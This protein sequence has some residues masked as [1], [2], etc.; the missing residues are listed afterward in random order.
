MIWAPCRH[1]WV[2]TIRHHTCIV[3]ESIDWQ[4]LNTYLCFR[5]LIFTTERHQHCRTTDCSIECFDKTFLSQYVVVLQVV[6]ETSTQCVAFYFTSKWIAFFYRTHC[7]ISK[8]SST[9]RIDKF[10]REV[11]N[12]FATIEHTH[13]RSISYIGNMHHFD[14]LFGAIFHELVFIFCLNYYRY[15]FLRLRDSEFCSVQAA[16]FCFHLVEVDIKTIS[17]LTDCHRYT[18]STEV[19]RFLNQAC[20]FRT[21]EEAFQFTFFRGITFLHFRRASFDRHHIMLFRRTCST[22]Y[23]IAT[24]T[25]TKHQHDIAR[26]WRFATHCISTHR[27]CHS[28]NFEAFSHIIR[29]I[30]FAQV[31]CCKTDLVTIA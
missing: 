11:N 10:A 22:T 5:A 3:S 26:S 28:T 19:V 27:T 20:H 21:T 8:V 12:S 4:F 9:S 14:I 29:V 7:C 16:I 25:T 1:E 6:F 2:E 15:A 31:S 13:T 18:T 30:D 23:T 24:C 17:Q